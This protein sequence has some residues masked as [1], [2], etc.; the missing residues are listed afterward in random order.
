MLS[1]IELGSLVSTYADSASCILLMQ[2]TQKLAV[3]NVSCYTSL[4]LPEG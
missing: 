3:S 4:H 1:G 2:L